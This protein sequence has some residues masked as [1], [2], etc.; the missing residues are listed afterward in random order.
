MQLVERES[1]AEPE[2]PI[3]TELAERGAAVEQA[4]AERFREVSVRCPECDSRATVTRT[5]SGAGFIIIAM[6]GMPVDTATFGISDAGLPI[7][8]NDNTGMVPVEAKPIAEAMAEANQQL[9]T[10]GAVQRPLF[11]P[12]PFDLHSAFA[13]II[14]QQERV[15]SKRET[16]EEAKKE[17]KEAKDDLDKAAELLENMIAKATADEREAIALGERLADP[18]VAQ[19]PPAE[20]QEK[21]LSELQEIA[22]LRKMADNPCSCDTDEDAQKCPACAAVDK[23][24]ALGV[25]VFED[26]P[27]PLQS[28]PAE[29]GTLEQLGEKIAQSQEDGAELLKQIT[30]GEPAAEPASKKK[31]SRKKRR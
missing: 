22:S 4:E 26:D 14:K 29:V 25:T 2:T 3:D 9:G 28:G 31:T 17:T 7:C 6:S 24:V 8:P 30:D 18:T 20:E 1:E 10:E 23:L 12:P 21:Q 5:E 13:Q 16:W 19:I 11:E 15:T 27:Q